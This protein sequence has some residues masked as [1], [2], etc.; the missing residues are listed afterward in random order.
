MPRKPTLDLFD[1]P[2]ECLDSLVRFT[3]D[4]LDRLQKQL[5]QLAFIQVKLLHQILVLTSL[6][7]FSQQ[8][9]FDDR[10]RHNAFVT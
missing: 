2:F 5:S 10:I 3:G 1:L 4:L 6:A 7:C 9:I 8:S